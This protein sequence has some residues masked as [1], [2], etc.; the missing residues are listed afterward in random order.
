MISNR[1]GLEEEGDC[2]ATWEVNLASGS[3]L[4]KY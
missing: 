2:S 1:G 3:F 4:P